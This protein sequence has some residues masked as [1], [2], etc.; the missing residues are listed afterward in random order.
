MPK[1]TCDLCLKEFSQKSHYIKHQNKKL[2][3]QDN[4]GKIENVVENNIINK[5]LITNNAENIITNTMENN[6]INKKLGAVNILKNINIEINA[7]E[8]IAIVGPSGAGKTTL[9]QILGTLS[10]PDSSSTTSLQ[11]DEANIL[12]LKENELSEFRNNKL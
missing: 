1:Y 5:K 11:I 12:K 10:S 6:F 8:I 3:C 7:G 9:L 4:K 2:P